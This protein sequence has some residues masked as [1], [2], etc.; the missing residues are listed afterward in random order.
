[1]EVKVFAVEILALIIPTC[2]LMQTTT[3]LFDDSQ[4]LG[5]KFDGI[6][7][8]SGGGATSKL[9]VNYPEKQRN[10][11]L[12]FL[13]KPNYGAS[14]Q[15]LKVEIGGDAQST[16][17][18]EAS[19]MHNSWDENYQRGYE[20][21]LMVEAKKRNSNIKLYGL[22]WGWPGWIGQGTRSPYTK[23]EV[24]ADYIIR[25][26]KGAKT[27][28]NLTIDFVGIWNEKP[29]DITYIKTLRKML[30]SGGLSNTRIVA[31]DGSWSIANEML[32]DQELSA[33]I[34]YIGCHYPGTLS[35]ENALKTGKQLW[36]SEDY[37]TFNDEVGG[38]CWARI[39][40]KNYAVGNM[41]ATISWN[42][43]AS[44][45]NPLP[46]YRDGLMT[47]VE[48]WSGN[49]VVETPIWLSAHT[50]QF[51]QVGWTY[52]LHGAGVGILEGGGS[53]ISMV[54]PDGKDLTIVMETMSHNHSL[55]IRPALPKYTVVPQNITVKLGGSFAAV[56]QMN[57]WYSKLG[58]NGQPSTM[59]EKQSAVTF[60]NGEAMLSLGVDE[61]YTLTTV[62]T[63]Q[64]GQADTPPP[65]KPFPL[66]YSDNFE[67]YQLGEEPYDLAPQT[68]SYEIVDSNSS[69]GKV[70]RQM[71]LQTPVQWCKADGI[72]A[73]LNVA[74]N[75]KW[76]D[77][78]VE[79]EVIL[80]S[81]NGTDGVFV[82]ARVQNGGC[83]S[84]SAKGVF[85]FLFP[86]KQMYIVTYDLARTQVLKTGSLPSK[87]PSWNKLALLVSGDEARGSVNGDS[88]FNVTVLLSPQN[89]FVA[90]G[91]DSYGIADFD[92]FMITTASEGERIMS[93][94][95]MK[96]S[97]DSLYFVR[98]VR[99]VMFLSAAAIP[100]LLQ[101]FQLP[102]NVQAI[103]QGQESQVGVNCLCLSLVL[104]LINTKSVCQYRLA[105]EF[106]IDPME[107][108]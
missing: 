75:Y 102:H 57:V 99:F 107:T 73:S 32:N 88:L 10:E 16:D 36:A 81:V 84:Y 68:G 76:T 96:S 86:E 47:A 4:G 108:T 91:T 40:N 18:T 92:N 2:A 51:T 23:P 3:Y 95:K 53:Y 61:V 71:V 8:L 104:G 24:T 78:Y 20:W 45:Y 79:A 89:G 106:L 49:Y 26:I 25:W 38:G 42:L 98:E 74:G 83:G 44:Y 87:L 93:K 35:T 72:G 60:K 12:D 41:T 46:F 65:S 15:I 37:S 59:F 48:P 28:Y 101:A 77:I 70:M 105:N 67:R 31:P 14:L 63:G 33:A 34:D 50:T 43:I 80:G 69:H 30:D 56:S 85:F 52:L 58:F 64:K 9:L 66:P 17:G 13:F 82:A 94:D 100:L 21:W 103:R 19:H 90:L 22:P 29:Y 54:S 27:Y 7:G 5:R 39:L 1:M 97:D 11:I 62:T 55:C 6:G